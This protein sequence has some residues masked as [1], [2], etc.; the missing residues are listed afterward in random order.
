MKALELTSY[1]LMPLKWCVPLYTF[2]FGTGP[3]FSY[4]LHTREVS[5]LS[6]TVRHIVLVM[7]LA[8]FYRGS[9][10]GFIRCG[11]PARIVIFGSGVCQ[12]IGPGAANTPQGIISR[13]LF[14]ARVRQPIGVED[15]LH[16]I[17]LTACYV[18]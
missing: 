9:P 18:L 13:H 16:F 10:S 8:V 15:Y 4:N 14:C 6:D 3:V 7:G 12:I 11:K 1:D 17:A 5:S 2:R